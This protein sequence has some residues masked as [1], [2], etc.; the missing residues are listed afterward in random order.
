VSY[1]LLEGDCLEVLRT[2]P[3]ASFDGVLSDPPYGLGTREP[4]ARQLAAYILGEGGLDMGGDFMGKTWQIPPVAVWREVFR[5]LKPGAH[6]LVFAGTRTQDL[7]S[8]GMRAAGFEIRDCIDWIYASGFPKSLDVSKAIDKAAGVERRV[9]SETVG[10]WKYANN[11]KSGTALGAES[12]DTDERGYL[13]S[14]VTAPATEEAARFAGYGTALKPAREPCILARKPLDG[15]VVQTVLEHGTGALAIDACRIAGAGAGT[16]CTNRSADGRCLGHGNAGRSTSGETFHGPDTAPE[17]RWP[18]NVVMSHD[19]GCRRVGTKRVS[20]GTA[21]RTNGGGRTF[22]GDEA[23]P[24]LADMSYAGPDGKEQVEAWECVD[25][26]PIA[27]LDAQSGDRPGMSGGGV[28]REGYGGGMFGGIDSAGT[29]RGDS[30]GASRFFFCA[31]ASRFEREFGCEDL[32]ALKADDLTNRDPDSAGNASAR[33]GAGRGAG[34]ARFRCASCGL[35]LGGGRAATP[36]PDGAHTPEF[37][38]IGPA[39]RNGHPTI[40]PIELARYLA[41]LILPPGE[42]RRLLVPYAGV[43]SEMIGALRAGWGHVVGIQRTADD[44]ERGYIRIAHARLKRW[45]EVPAHVNP[46]E[47]EVQERRAE[48]GSLFG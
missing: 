17:G 22:G 8:I 6:L 29:A 36:C 25:D 43:G 24:A 12:R 14:R 18:A 44:D 27:M 41:R 48:Q 42:G 26:C 1:E 5:V 35:H 37:I 39:V 15:T 38:G 9:V 2:L 40:K 23:K 4:T 46:T 7:I 11:E 30:G 3:E 21:H 13:I 45:A 33:A 31:K 16:N 28:H 19:E 10:R 20:T 32:P 47:C 34:A